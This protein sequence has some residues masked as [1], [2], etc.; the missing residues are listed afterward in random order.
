[1]VVYNLGNGSLV[2]TELTAVDPFGSPAAVFSLV[3]PNIN[4]TPIPPG[5]LRVVELAWDRSQVVAGS[6]NASET[7]HIARIHP[8]TSQETV[9]SVALQLWDTGSSTAPTA[10]LGTDADY[11]GAT[12]G[13]V[14]VLGT[15][16]L[17]P[18]SYEFPTIYG[19]AYW[20]L[21]GKPAASGAVLNEESFST[22]GFLPDVPGT[23]DIELFVFSIDGSDV[24]YSEPAT[25]SLSVD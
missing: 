17:D 12:A 13:E 3:D 21:T 25:L 7:L 15:Q 9:V 19:F 11:P 2:L 6:D 18:G 5:G 8:I 23:Y 22:S 14:V 1:M 10:S 24:L 4:A 16:T 20:Y